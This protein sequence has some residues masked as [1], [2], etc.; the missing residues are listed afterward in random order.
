MKPICKFMHFVWYF[1]K[2]VKIRFYRFLQQSCELQVL[3]Y[4]LI[5]GIQI[6]ALFAQNL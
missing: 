1:W 4:C 3:H 2:D 6:T 5:R